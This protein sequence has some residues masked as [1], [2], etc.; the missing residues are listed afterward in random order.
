L[1]SEEVHLDGVGRAVG[2]EGEGTV[3]VG[4]LKKSFW[5]GSHDIRV[6]CNGG[7]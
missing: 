1:G 2:L 3:V 6:R 4:C 7:R 5:R